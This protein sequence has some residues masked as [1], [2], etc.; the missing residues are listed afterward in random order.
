MS[1][2]LGLIAGIFVT[3]F[4]FVL[5]VVALGFWLGPPDR[6]GRC[7]DPERK[8]TSLQDMLRPKPQGFI[9][10]PPDEDEEARAEKIAENSAQNKSTKLSEL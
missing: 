3:L 7:A 8:I 4:F 2:F 1:F 6:K 10:I 9:Y 5:F